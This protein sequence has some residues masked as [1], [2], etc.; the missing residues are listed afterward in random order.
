[1]LTVKETPV[2]ILN[3]SSKKLYDIADGVMDSN[4]KVHEKW[5]IL[6]NGK[7]CMVWRF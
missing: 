3:C 6:M 1:M 4:T 7:N 2:N 5:K